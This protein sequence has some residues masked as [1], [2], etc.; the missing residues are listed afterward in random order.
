MPQAFGG[1]LITNANQIAAG[2]IT[3]AH[4]NAA[5]AIASSKLA[6]DAATQA[7]LD[8]H[9]AGSGLGG[10]IQATGITNA[11]VAAAAAIVGSK[12][13]L[14]LSKIAIVA[15]S[16]AQ[17]ISNNTPTKINY[18]VE[19]ADTDTMHDNVTN[20]TRITIK[21]AGKYHIGISGLW[22]AQVGGVRKTEIKLN[23]GAARLSRTVSDNGGIGFYYSAD[24]VTEL[25]L[26]DYLEVEVTQDSGSSVYW[27]TGFSPA[28]VFWAYLIPE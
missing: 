10:H 13:A 11:E 21:T 3:N 6:D 19:Y 8:T 22:A 5:A 2:I 27:G 24:I 17:L 4:I 26:N 1:S 7:E 14:T 20:N 25:S 18:G 23:N 28:V 9:A 12:L 15:Q 16:T